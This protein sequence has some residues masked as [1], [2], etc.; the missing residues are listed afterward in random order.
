MSRVRQ[1]DL[2]DLPEADRDVLARPINLYRVL[3]HVPEAA[4]RYRE[5]GRWI[6]FESQ[7]DPRLRELVI[8][9]V[10][11]VTGNAYESTHHVHIGA[12]CGVS[13]A[14]VAGVLLETRGG[15]SQFT[16]HEQAVLRAT[17]QLTVDA[18]IDEATWSALRARMSDAELVE[19]TTVVAFYAMTIRVL[20]ALQPDVE[21]EYLPYLDQL[22]GLDQSPD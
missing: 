2:A 10:G 19:L 22:P 12:T 20:A 21:P 7:M 1:L 4:R 15:G 18:R 9:Q 16:E 17:R 14:D 3:A 8:L 5:L 11:V 13:P 6:R